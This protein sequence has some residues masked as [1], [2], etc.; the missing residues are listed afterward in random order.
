[1]SVQYITPMGRPPG[2]EPSLQVLPRGGPSFLDSPRHSAAKFLS[3]SNSE[4]DEPPTPPPKDEPTQTQGL[5][6]PAEIQ[7]YFSSFRASRTNSIYSLSRMSFSSQLSQ[8]TS[9]SLPQASSLSSSISSLPTA[10]AAANALS[11]AAEQIR[12]WLQKASE[13]L[14]GLDGED[15]VEWAAAGGREGLE[16]VDS[17]IGNFEGL[18]GIYVSAI[19]GLQARED[20]A[21]LPKEELKDLVDQMERTLQDWENVRYLLKGV[22]RQ[23][24]LAMEWEE[25]WNVVLGDIGL[26]M[27]N[28]GRLV[29]Q[30]EETRH[31]AML[32]EPSLEGGHGIDMQ[33]LETI[34]EEAPAGG[35]SP[36]NHRFSL[37]P[38]FAATSP[39]TSPHTNVQEDSTLLALFARM[40]P[41]RASLDFLP[42]TLSSFNARAVDVLP[43]ACQELEARRRGLETKWKKLESDAEGL[44]R[45]LGEDRWVLVFRNAGRQAQ[46]LCESVE[47]SIS[48][49]QE[50]I[51]VGTQH[52]NP[53]ALAKRVD[54][55]EQ[56]KVHYG[57]AIDRVLAIIEKGVNDRLTINGEILRLHLDTRARWTAMK[58]EM[59]DMDLALDDLNINKNQQLR[60][61]ISSIVSNDRSAV[62][63]GVDTPR[64]S[65]PS[66]VAMGPTNGHKGDTG[67]LYTNAGSRHTSAISG[68]TTRPGSFKR[69]FS[70][71]S[72]SVLSSQ[73]SRRI[74]GPRSTMNEFQAASGAIS[75]SPHSEKTSTTPLRS[76][77]HQRPSTLPSDKP[78][79]NA[80]PKI[81]HIDFTNTFKSLRIST[82]TPPSRKSSTPL[83]SPRSVTSQPPTSVLPLPSPL[84]HADSSPSPALPTLHRPRL[85]SGIPS[86]SGQMTST[87]T[88]PSH[89]FTN[90][91]SSGPHH[92][93]PSSS[94]SRRADTSPFGMGT[95]LQPTDE[96]S[97]NSNHVINRL[98][99]PGT[100]LA[101]D[102]RTSM[103]PLPKV[104][105][106]LPTIVGTPTG[107][108]GRD[109]SGAGIRSVPRSGRESAAGGALF[110]GRDNISSAGRRGENN[111]IIREQ[112]R[113]Q[114]AWK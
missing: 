71:P 47:R 40:Q 63:S 67:A 98:T 51:D 94:F 15:D 76:S 38:A 92:H 106:V 69:Y 84:R 56:K 61:S 114:R 110:G 93:R 66:S 34:V 20:V 104:V 39:I 88:R 95:P 75:T 65:P 91:A 79:W 23:V 5:T 43:T 108:Q 54:S 72:A 3:S 86:F 24:E 107:G 73:I 14:G 112:E 50:C 102:R 52:S 85:S 37:P 83:P 16:E 12:Q 113:E 87:P 62:G 105:S 10:L 9:L 100:S 1:M 8:L 70:L 48:K 97:P 111:N 78:R 109:G 96:L 80:S 11:G 26:E 25:L 89:T 36:A 59:K 68:S 81:D 30:M 77:R 2:L 103:L 22:K 60:D 46:K 41:L 49:L 45:E 90:S 18:I 35:R 32:A 58:L 29:F 74:S 99:R 57:P 53:A 27:D 13:M 28:L 64:S 6:K 7:S 31:K 55:Y 101:H 82:K 42:M 4:D 19:E 44:R 17:A 21:N 33:E